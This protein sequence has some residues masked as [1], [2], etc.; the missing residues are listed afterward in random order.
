[1]LHLDIER[2]NILQ[3]YLRRR[4]WLDTEEVISSVE[5]P[6]EGK[7][8]VTLR[9]TT[10]NRTLIVK[11]S[12]EY[13]EKFSAI[14]APGNRISNEG[15]FYQ[16]I[17]PVAMLASYMPEFLG[18]DDENNI[19]VLRDLGSNRPYTFL[20]ESGQTL[21]E[22]EVAELTNYLSE[23]HLHFLT[24]HPNPAL[25][26]RDMRILTY[27]HIF[28]SPFLDENGFDLDT[29]QPGLQQLA[30]VYKQDTK[31]KKV[32]QEVGSLYLADYQAGDLTTLLH[33]D[34]CPKNWLKATAGQFSGIRVIDP[35]RCFYGP[36]EFD[37]GVMM[38]HLMLAQQ[39]GAAL[40]TVLSIYEKPAGFN[41]ILRQ[42]FTGVELMRRLIGIRQ[43]PLGLSIDQ[44]QVLLEEAHRMLQ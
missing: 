7:M 12:R 26:N 32:I 8:N 25:A 3:D 6:G 33:G 44:K 36:P 13:V 11:Q 16:L 41:D 15:R 35:E 18:I 23:L 30:M 19:L 38:A 29:V 21:N 5:E 4:G 39:P 34:Y 40:E 27:D 20:Y 17:Q 43:L 28:N 2:I 9:V 10:P 42:R 22:T 14:P 1:M 37:V 31:L 24:D